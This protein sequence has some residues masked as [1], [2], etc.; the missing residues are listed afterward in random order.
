MPPPPSRK[1]ANARLLREPEPRRDPDC[2]TTMDD[3]ERERL[4]SLLE[5]A[6]ALPPEQHARFLEAKRGP[7]TSLREEWASPNA[8]SVPSAGYVDGLSNQALL[9]AL[10]AAARSSMNPTA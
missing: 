1:P 5:E 4:G 6:L 2:R 8:A 7:H 10:A 3:L 9:K